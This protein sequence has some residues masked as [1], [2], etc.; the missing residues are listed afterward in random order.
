VSAPHPD[1]VL[2]RAAAHA[3]LEAV[4]SQPIIQEVGRVAPHPD[5]SYRLLVPH[6]R[7]ELGRLVNPAL[8]VA[9]NLRSQ[10]R[11]EAFVVVS[12]RDELEVRT[13]NPVVSTDGLFLWAQ[14][15][16]S[17]VPRAV[18]AFLDEMEEP[19]LGSAMF[20]DGALAGGAR[21][22]H[23]VLNPEQQE[24]A[25]LILSHGTHAVWGPPGTGKTSV[26][27]EVITKVISSGKTLCL[28]SNTNIAVDHAVLSASKATRLDKPGVV[29]RVGNTTLSEV[30]EHPFLTAERAAAMLGK[31]LSE[32]LTE[33]ELRL[34]Q[35]E[36]SPDHLFCRTFREFSKHPKD[37]LEEACE[38]VRL[39]ST[40]QQVNASKQLAARISA[41][42]KTS[43]DLLAAHQ[44]THG[45]LRSVASTSD[46]LGDRIQ[47]ERAKLALEDSE[48][49]DLL[50]A[51][52]IA[53]LF[54]RRSIEQAHLRRGN[55]VSILKELVERQAPLLRQLSKAHGAGVTPSTFDEL[56]AEVARLRA[57]LGETQATTERLQQCVTKLTRMAPSL[58]EAAEFIA[59][60]DGLQACSDRFN[61]YQDSTEEQEITK[62][63]VTIA[64][65][66]RELAEIESK[67]LREAQVIG[68]TLAQLFVNSSLR[69]RRFDYV[70]IDEVSAA[71]PTMALGA[72]SKADKSATAV[73]DFE[74]NGPISNVKDKALQNGPAWKQWVRLNP[75]D[76]LNVGDAKACV[77]SAGCAVLRTQYR[78]GQITMDIA[79]EATYEGLLNRP[80]IPSP[81]M[82][83]EIIVVDCQHMGDLAR[84]EQGTR[85]R[86]RLWYLGAALSARIATGYEPTEI[87]V[88][89]PYKAQADLMRWVLDDVGLRATS[90]GT[91]HSFQGREFPA[92]VFD[93]VEPG[94]ATSW[95]AKATRSGSS[96]TRSG[97]RVFNVAITRNAGRL[98]VL[99]NANQLRNARGPLALLGRRIETGEVTVVDAKDILASDYQ[100]HAASREVEGPEAIASAD[101]QQCLSESI[102]SATERVVI[103]APNSHGEAANGL[104]MPIRNAVKRGV[105]VTLYGNNPG[106]L[107]SLAAIGART[108]AFSGNDKVVL[109]DRNLTFIGGHNP[110]AGRP[111]P[112]EFML[113]FGGTDMNRYVSQVMKDR[114]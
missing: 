3:E 7:I 23:P 73:G 11:V 13:D 10:E 85:G 93:L 52:R 54:T 27:A 48:L 98:F 53:K 110:L 6:P 65:I 31:E 97:L 95:V 17:L 28:A 91:I 102:E 15:D 107:S 2:A 61:R 94:D 57:E 62:L 26:I 64:D 21:L 33:T 74:Q 32:K 42:L 87:G 60:N 18:A 14:T 66:D 78:F 20:R 81:A 71:L 111:E 100:V 96:F 36:A 40:M 89:T 56:D 86:S 83:P 5:D 99:G 101:F 4:R 72:L 50:S 108:R 19:E 113:R 41:E 82:E 76:F 92:V 1:L 88:I 77:E 37:K 79:N 105:A 90:A 63:R 114:L 58:R 22:S 104:S 46:S 75:F 51:G 84:W 59:S 67:V 55:I 24:A 70:I 80:N 29:V 68:T 30:A 112:S 44:R 47:V 109:V 69:E 49:E 16:P 106:R 45:D 38:L 25:G 39:P 43:M 8:F 12:S 103:F 34:R 35:L 9:A